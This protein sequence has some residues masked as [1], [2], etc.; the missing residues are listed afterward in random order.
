MTTNQ[1]E[2][3]WKSIF[4]EGLKAGEHYQISN[5]GRIRHYKP[6][7]ERWKILKN[8]NSKKDG[9][10]YEYFTW[11]KSEKGWRHKISKPIHRLVGEYFINR[12][13]DNHNFIIHIDHNKTNNDF[14]NLRWATQQEVINHNKNNPRVLQARSKQKGNRRYSK[15][16][17][18]EV[19]RIKH[20]LKRGKTA[21][22]KIAKEFG[23]THTQL[24]RIRAGENWGH[25]KID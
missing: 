17:E 14:Q 12:P 5:H 16:T 11:F 19:I 3:E 21:L 2:E 18:T 22:Y 24:N 25:I 8:T 13:S 23:I 6:K 15:L 7:E 1:W 4:F 9:T 20:K 10:G